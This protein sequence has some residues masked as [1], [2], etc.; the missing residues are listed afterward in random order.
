MLVV[1]VALAATTISVRPAAAQETVAERDAMRAE[2]P[3]YERFTSSAGP[4]QGLSGLGPALERGA[5]A[6]S[7]SNRWGITVDL[8]DGARRLER[9]PSQSETSVGA[10][11]QFTPR[12]RLGGQVSVAEQ[13]QSAPNRRDEGEH[14]NAGVRLESA[15][16]F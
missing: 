12:V 4:T 14:P 16:R 9:A 15:F 10:F 7:P 1:G 2:T 8:R 11:Y 3:W 6:W 13:P 5:P